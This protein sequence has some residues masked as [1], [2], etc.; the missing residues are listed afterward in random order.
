MRSW[1]LTGFG[2]VCDGPIPVGTPE[3][4][5]RI[6]TT[7]AG[8]FNGGPEGKVTC[9]APESRFGYCIYSLI[10]GCGQAKR[11][12]VRHLK[13]IGCGLCGVVIVELRR[14]VPARTMLLLKD[15]CIPWTF[16]VILRHILKRAENAHHAHDTHRS[17]ARRLRRSSAGPRVTGRAVERAVCTVMS[18]P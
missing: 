3:G 10:A 16:A 13:R 8:K 4:C 15:G 2:V 6:N 9:E 11:G 1:V 17:A 12:Q 7:G 18:E 5:L 14:M